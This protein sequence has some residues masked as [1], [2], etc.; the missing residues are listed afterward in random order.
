MFAVHGGKS[1]KFI[2]S[3]LLC[4]SLVGLSRNFFLSL[5]S[6]F[7]TVIILFMHGHGVP[8]WNDGCEWFY[9]GDL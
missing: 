4:F 7:T 1:G 5:S 9:D 8:E 2:H 3:F 6:N